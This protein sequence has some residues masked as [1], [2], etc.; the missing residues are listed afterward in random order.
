MPTLPGQGKL[1]VQGQ[2]ERNNKVKEKG[3]Q[4][5]LYGQNQRKLSFQMAQEAYFFLF[6]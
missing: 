5:R 2:E 4:K 6:V 1:F 3:E